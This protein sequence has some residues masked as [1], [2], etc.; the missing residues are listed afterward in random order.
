MREMLRPLVGHRITITAIYED[1][2]DKPDRYALRP[3]SIL[4]HDVEN[5]YTGRFLCDHAW[6]VQGDLW[7]GT[8]LQ[9]GDIVK[10]EVL[11][12]MYWKGYQGQYK[13]GRYHPVRID[14]GFTAVTGLQRLRPG[15]R[16]RRKRCA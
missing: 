1:P 6:L 5:A 2:I 16:P 11:V 12:E 7:V 10:L 8:D 14:F 9:E 13:D 3:Y 4:L 15:L